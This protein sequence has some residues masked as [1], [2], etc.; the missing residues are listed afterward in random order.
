MKDGEAFRKLVI[1][2]I[3]WHIGNQDDVWVHSDGWLIDS[4]K[5]IFVVVYT[6]AQVKRPGW[7]I[8]ADNAIFQVVRIELFSICNADGV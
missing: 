8:Q 7:I 6:S 1:P 3:Y 4:L 2:T 5:E